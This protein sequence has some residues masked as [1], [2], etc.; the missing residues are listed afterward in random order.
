MVLV[1]CG[2]TQKT[3]VDTKDLSYLYNPSKSSIKP[4]YSVLNE[5]DGISILSVKLFA[6]DLFFSEANPQGIP[7]AKILLTAK[8]FNTTNGRALADT[9][10]LDAD[11]VKE[12]ARVP[13]F[14]S[15]SM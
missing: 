9:A 5:S 12:A 11:I 7:I 2:T 1:S 15:F 10:Y 3:V 8:L 4:R 6:Q 13:S 14:F